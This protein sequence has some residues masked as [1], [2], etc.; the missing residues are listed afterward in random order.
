MADNDNKTKQRAKITL[1][2]LNIFLWAVIIITV[3][4]SAYHFCNDTESEMAKIEV[5]KRIDVTPNII[6]AMNEI[7]EWEFLSIND[8]ELVDTIRKGFFSDDRLVRIYYGK[9][10]IGINMHKATPRWI[11]Q[12]G[13]DSIAVRLPKVEL[14][15]NNF[16]DE[17]RS[18]AFIETGKW[19]D[20]DR[21]KMYNTAYMKMKQRCLTPQNM[22]TAKDNAKEQI[23]K[24][25]KAMGVEKYSVEFD[26]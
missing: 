17:A 1:T 8:E 12:V 13:T 18:K 5:E 10:S 22:N 15:D 9:L 6:T 26:N 2:K 25:L 11:K 14:L 21:E 7:G 19:S 4:I 3:I 16:I 23:G 20:A 24:M